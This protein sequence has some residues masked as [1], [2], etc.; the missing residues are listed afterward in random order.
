MP[1][2]TPPAAQ[3]QTEFTTT[4]KGPVSILDRVFDGLGCFSFFHAELCQFG[5]HPVDH[6]FRIW[7]KYISSK[8][9]RLQA[10]RILT[11]FSSIRQRGGFVKGYCG[12]IS[13]FARA[14]AIPLNFH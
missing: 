4:I 1:G 3:P 5:T 14:H 6:H 8:S 7:H 11:F 2:R 9:L 10:G 12:L 13:R